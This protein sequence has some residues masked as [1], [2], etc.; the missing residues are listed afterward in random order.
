MSDQY[1]GVGDAAR[2]I[3]RREGWRALW[4]GVGPAVAAVAP[5]VAVQ[6]SV[7]D[8]GKQG[9]RLWLDAEPSAPLFA[10]CGVAAGVV[11]QTTIYPLDVLRRR[12]QAPPAAGGAPPPASA[13][14][15]LRAVLR[16]GGPR[17]LWAGIIPA[18][19]RVAPTVAISLLVRDTLLG[20]L[21]RKKDS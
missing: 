1:R 18:W 10:S 13:A 7:Y 3:V 16:E 11:A 21:D 6:Q 9:A 2:C 4:Q 20:R 8:V 19:L 15:A 14:E 5:F 12:M 17:A